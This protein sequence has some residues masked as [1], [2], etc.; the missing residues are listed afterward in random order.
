MLDQVRT[1]VSKHASEPAVVGIDRTITYE[2]LWSTV[3]RTGVALGERLAPNSVVAIR[4]R[5]GVDL[6]GLFLGV[7]AAGAVPFLLDSYLPR[8]RAENLLAAVRPAAVIH[9]A[10]E[11]RISTGVANARILPDEAGYVTFT[12]GSQ[13]A[14]KGIIGNARGLAAFLDW[15]NDELDLEPGF[16]AAMLT[17]PSF[18]VVLREML[19]PLVRGGRLHVAGPGVRTDARSVLAWLRAEDI[20]LVHLVPSLST[21]WLAGNTTTAPGLRWSLFAGEPLYARH[22]RQWRQAAPR[23]RIGNLYGPSE[24]TL[25]KFWFTGDGPDAGLWP[26]GHPLPGTV[27]RQ[28][29]DATSQTGQTFRTV[30][31]TPDGS[32]GYLDPELHPDAAATLSRRDGVTAFET[33]DRGR[34]T[35]QG[36]L[37]VEGRLD[38]VVKRRG[39]A[40]DLAS[41][42]AAALS[43]PGVRAACCLQVDRD[44][45]G[46]LVLALETDAVVGDRE[47]VNALRA[48]LGP[49]MPDAVLAVAKL[50]R[51]PSGK[52]NASVVEDDLRRGDT[53]GAL[54]LGGIRGRVSAAQ[55]PAGGREA[56]H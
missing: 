3:E 41:I 52:V 36:A 12:S 8:E 9:E 47:L 39:V 25:A 22:V 55:E 34:L 15:E 32:L 4:A 30:I 21:R 37:V 16:R 27:L 14:P 45:D 26:V 43:E 44:I 13:G 1:T 33:Q 29:P 24:T 18:D 38:S 17:S 49:S 42:T 50:P 6:P 54:L 35:P 11:P 48:A 40:V 5:G 28:L 56:G 23:T 31:E 7:R 46:D 19:V 2:E 51:L 10:S 20:D 53:Q